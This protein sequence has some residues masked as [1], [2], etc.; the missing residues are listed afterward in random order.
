MFEAW[1]DIRHLAQWWGP[2]R[3]R[4]TTHSFEFRPGGV[5]D[6]TVTFVEKGGA[7]EITMR[8]VFKTREKRAEVIE[9]YGALEGGRQTLGRL[10]ACIAAIDR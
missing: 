6:S 4:T 3:F 10:V 1:T 7:T 2:N 8:S 5:W 9:K